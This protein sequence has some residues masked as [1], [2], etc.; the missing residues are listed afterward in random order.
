[1]KKLKVFFDWFLEIGL[2][3]IIVIFLIVAPW[4]LFPSLLSA[5]ADVNKRESFAYRGILELWHVETFEG[6]SVSRAKFLE[7]QAID[8]EKQNKGCYIVIQTMTLE[9]FELNLQ[10]SKRPNMISFGIGASDKIVNE[11]VELDA[12]GVRT[13]LAKYGQFG[14]R[15]LA[16]PY[17]LGGYALI[18]NGSGAVGVGLKG[19]TNPLCAMQKNNLQIASMFNETDLDSYDAYDKFL[20]GSFETLLGTQRD[21]YRVQNRQQKGLMTDVVFKFLGCYTD[22]VQYVSVFKGGQAEEEMCKKFVSLLLDKKSQSELADYNLFSTLSNVTLYKD[23]LYKDFEQTLRQP[24]TSENAFIST[25]EIDFKKQESYK[26][27]VS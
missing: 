11:L 22:L 2:S 8:F 16:V 7:R 24:L 10:N 9:Q 21:F 17:I 5:Q 27:V 25:S 12:K 14:Y 4:T 23:G 15:Q 18:K 13:D 3:A 19:T 6:G 1:M 20:K 26:N